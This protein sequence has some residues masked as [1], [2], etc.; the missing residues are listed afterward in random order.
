MTSSHFHTHRVFTQHTSVLTA[1]R[2]GRLF[3][4]DQSPPFPPFSTS[5]P[6]SHLSLV[7]LSR[8]THR[9]T[10]YYARCHSSGSEPPRIGAAFLV[11]GFSGQSPFPRI[12]F[13]AFDPR[14]RAESFVLSRR[15]HTA[16][17]ERPQQRVFS[18]CHLPH[19]HLRLGAAPQATPHPSRPPRGG[20]GPP[21]Q[22]G[23]HHSSHPAP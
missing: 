18:S 4:A 20:R 11:C 23:T 1:R 17:R 2:F 9:L 15:R 19:R 3:F 21:R 12:C 8:V 7:L 10:F 16:W 6:T 5:H 22:P 14:S 13:R